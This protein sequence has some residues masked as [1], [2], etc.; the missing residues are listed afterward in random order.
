MGCVKSKQGLSK[1]DLEFLRTHTRYDENTIKEWYKGFKQDCPNGKLTPVKFVDMYKMFW[2]S[3]NAEQFCDHVFRTFDTDKNG[4]ID[5]KEFLLAIDVTSAGTAEK[6]LKWA[7]RIFDVDGNG[8][9][10]QEEMTKI[11]QAIY[12]MLG[13]GATKPTD[14]AEERAKNIFSRMDENGDGHLTEEEFLSGCLQDDELSKMLAP[15]VVQ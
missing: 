12:D 3:G 6:T 4:F 9:I 7:F 15:N 14:S 5:F 13:A 1:E 11:V 10:D 2:P 8:V